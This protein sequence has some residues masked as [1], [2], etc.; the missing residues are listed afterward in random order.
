MAKELKTFFSSAESSVDVNVVVD[1]DLL[2]IVVRNDRNIHVSKN[3]KVTKRL[4]EG[5]TGLR[6]KLCAPTLSGL[7]RISD[8]LPMIK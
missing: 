1:L 2:A 6:G 8:S 5:C 3:P 7:Y 4:F